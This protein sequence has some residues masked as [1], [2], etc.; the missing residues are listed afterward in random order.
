MIPSALLLGSI[1]VLADCSEMQRRAYNLAFR[2]ADLDWV[3]DRTSY[4]RLLRRPGG[5]RRIRDYA[6]ASGDAVDVDA[7]HRAK[8]RTF[9]AL[10]AREGLEPRP[11]V[12]VTVS[13]ARASGVP[14]AL[15]STAH[16]EQVA[17]VLHAL[18]RW[19]PQGSFDWVGDADATPRPKPAPDAFDV[20][21][22]SL[23]ADRRRALA[24][25]DTPECA[26]AAMDAGCRAMGFPGEASADRD[27]PSGVLVVDRLRPAVL[28]L[29]VDGGS[30]PRD[31]AAQ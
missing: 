6:R 17:T 11:G 20:A 28:G 3:W 4:R 24:V 9:A 29:P 23:R 21:L 8:R 30:K 14:V 19:I 31:L 22:R 15:C 18:E 27:F 7:L 1:G 12:V 16:P 5:A 13:A 2:D 25:E 10:V 26:Q